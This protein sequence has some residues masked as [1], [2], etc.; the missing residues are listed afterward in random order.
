MAKGKAKKVSSGGPHKKHGP[1]KHMFKEYKPMIRQFAQLGLLNKYNEY[2]SWV[3]ACTAR[4]KRNTPYDEFIK[5]ST[6][7]REEK[8]KYF[9]NLRK[10]K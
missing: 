7:S 1:K 8:D 2:E 5:F 4:G 9:D 10:E 6:L 3:L